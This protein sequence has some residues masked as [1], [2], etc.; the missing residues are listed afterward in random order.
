MTTKTAKSAKPDSKKAGRSNLGE[1]R[2]KDLS[3]KGNA[4]RGR[5]GRRAAPAPV[6][7]P[8]PLLAR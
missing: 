7:V 5:R 6:P 1:A 3:P 2:L 4:V 8:Y